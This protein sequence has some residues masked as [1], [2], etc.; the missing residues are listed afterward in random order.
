[1]RQMQRDRSRGYECAAEHG[2]TREDTA[3]GVRWGTQVRIE[4]DNTYPRN[5]NQTGDR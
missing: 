3:L 5:V 2:L 4:P 1:M